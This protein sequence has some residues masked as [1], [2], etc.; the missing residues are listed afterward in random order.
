MRLPFYHCRSSNFNLFLRKIQKCLQRREHSIR[1]IELQYAWQIKFGKV[2]ELLYFELNFYNTLKVIRNSYP[3][4]HSRY[5]FLPF[6]QIVLLNLQGANR[7]FQHHLVQVHKVHILR[8]L[9][10]KESD[11]IIDICLQ[12][13]YLVIVCVHLWILTP[14]K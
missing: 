6:N 12:H 14:L 1:L 10:T 9:S 2:N 3:C 8:Q 4:I 7:D 11:N 13:Q 5:P